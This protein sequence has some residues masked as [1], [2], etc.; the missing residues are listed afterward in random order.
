[1]VSLLSSGAVGQII[2]PQEEESE[3]YFPTSNEEV[4]DIE[5]EDEE[6]SENS[7]IEEIFENKNV[8]DTFNEQNSETNK[9]QQIKTTN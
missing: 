7:Y 9:K 2:I 8:K 3:N 5:S 6:N 4:I 1:M